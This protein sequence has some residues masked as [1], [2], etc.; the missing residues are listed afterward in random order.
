MKSRITSWMC[1]W[2]ENCK[3]IK[4]GNINI[5]TIFLYGMSFGIPMVILLFVFQC[6]EFYPFGGKTLFIMDMKDQ[7]LAFFSSLRNVVS[8]DDSLFLSWSRSMGGNYLGLFAYYVASPLSFLTVFFPVEKL[9]SAIVFLT[10]LKIGLAGVSFACFAD[11]FWKR[12]CMEGTQRKAGVGKKKVYCPK[13]I[14]KKEGNGNGN[15]RRLLAVV[16]LAVSYALISYNMVY[17]MCLMWLDGVILLPMVLL[18]IEKILDGVGKITYVFALTAL[19]YCNYYTGYMVGIFTAIYTIYRILSRL[20]KQKLKEYIG[21]FFHIGMSTLFAFGLS[22]P[23]LFPVAN[24]LM[25]G[26]LT[27]SSYMPNKATNFVFADLFGKLQNGVYDSI[28]NSGLP[29]IYCGYA[30]LV[31][32]AA[33]FVLRRISVREKLGAAL[34][35]ALFSCS[36]YWIKWDMVWHGF[37]YPTWFPF[38]YAFV[39]SFFLLYMA[40]RS[41]SVIC[42]IK[43]VENCKVRQII[44]VTGFLL[45][46]VSFD[47]GINGNAMFRGLEGQFAYVKVEDYEAFLNKTQPIIKALQE[48]D[49]GFYRINQGFEFSKNDAMLLGYHGMTHYSSTFHGAVNTLTPKLGIAQKHIWNSGYGSNPLL[50]SLFGVKYILEDGMVSTGYLLEDSSEEGGNEKVVSVYR[51]PNVLPIVYGASC[52]N[53]NPD[54]RAPNPYVN[55][56]VLLN[57]ITG[58]S[59]AYF[60]EY[61]YMTE[62]LGSGW[63]YTFTADSANPVYLYM[64]PVKNSW[65]NVYVNE[66]WVGNYFSSETNCS[67]YLGEFEPGEHVRVRVSPK[68][69]AEVSAAMIAQ[70]HMDLLEETMAELSENGMWIDR[71]ES[72]RLS[73]RILIGEQQKIITS[74]PYDD[75][76]T[77]RIDGRKVEAVQFAETFLAV[78]AE[79]GEHSISFTYVSPGFWEGMAVF[80]IAAMGAVI[81]FWNQKC[82]VQVFLRKLRHADGK[83]DFSTTP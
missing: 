40:L 8:G 21:K 61:E 44:A 22:A 75:G 26:K 12:T 83:H 42:S 14:Q 52:V 25:Q 43:R 48:R 60:S 47:M 9:T 56:N 17:S 2:M 39:C 30:A 78:E 54:L 19:F 58:K 1:T 69:E 80:G 35:L 77:V 57:A 51:N 76:W 15:Y 55:Q 81:Y 16:P 3:A 7:Y 33:F 41:F 37:Q 72:G 20:E 59:H 66:K 62:T 18:G 45:V 73:G 49:G 64:K 13:A 68:G 6:Q 34:I 82:L 53:L 10:L 46:A 79:S 74:I 5:F 28:T 71:H 38:R 63:V 27:R 70:L 24:D 4:K 65:A 36:F 23:L 11:Y 31:L 50:D 32:A 67:L 29:S